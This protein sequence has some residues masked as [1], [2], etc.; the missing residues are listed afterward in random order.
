MKL[1]K[2][3]VLAASSTAFLFLVGCIGQTAEVIGTPTPS[4]SPTPMPELYEP[5]LTTTPVPMD[6]Y[7]K[8]LTDANHYF[9]YL[10]FSD[11]TVY[12]YNGSTHLDGICVNSF[13]DSLRGRLQV[14]YKDKNGKLCG[15]GEIITAE[16]TLVLKPGSNAIYS[17]ILTDTNVNDMEFSFVIAE[18]FIPVT[19]N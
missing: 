3:F 10:T 11:L 5:V 14:I 1:R 6:A 9:G 12:D 18:D 16:G 15:S 2:H 8:R 17:E 7:G 13:S 19:D 4:S